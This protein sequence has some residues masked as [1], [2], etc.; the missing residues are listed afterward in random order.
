M[1]FENLE[2]RTISYKKN[3]GYCK[4]EDR[5]QLQQAYIYSD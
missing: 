2:F 5:I 3:Y 1:N 4:T